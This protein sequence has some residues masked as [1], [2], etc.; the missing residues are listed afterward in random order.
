MNRLFD[1]H[2]KRS[3]LSLDGLWQF[4]TDPHGLGESDR[5][6]ENFPED[7]TSVYVPS[8]W[9]NELGLYDY[10][11]VAWYGKAFHS[12]GDTIQLA[13]HGVTG[14]ANVYLDGIFLG[15]HYGGFTGFDFTVND[16]KTGKHHLAVSVD[17]RH[18]D[19]D[20]IPLAV[21]DWFHYG[22]ITRGVEVIRLPETRIDRYRIDYKLS[23]DLTEVDLECQ[24]LVTGMSHPQIQ[25]Y[26]EGRPI[27]EN[28]CQPTK[29]GLG[30]LCQCH[31][32]DIQLW[33]PDH[34]NLYEIRIA[35]DGDEV[36]EHIGFRKIEAVNRQ[37]L[38]NGQPLYLKGVNRHEDHPDWGFALPVKL[39]MKDLAIIKSMGCNMI[40]GSHYPN[41][42]AFLDLC[43]REGILFMEEIPM[44]GFGQEALS[45][46]LVIERGL[47][48][49]EEMINRDYHHPCIFLW[50]LHNECATDTEA[51]YAITKAFAD[52]VRSLDQTRPITYATNK[53]HRDICLSLVDVISINKYV[54]WYMD[55]LDAWPAYLQTFKEKAE[56]DHLQD[57]PIIM[58]EFGAGALY[59]YSTFEG[60]KWSEN[61]QYNYLDY[62][63]KLFKDDPDISGAVLWQFC[64]IR[65]A[66]EH[67][68]GRPRSFNNKGILD[69]YRRPKAAYWT[70]KKHYSQ[71]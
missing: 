63:L 38:L 62:T 39:M 42:P 70:V 14:Q 50:G 28:P 26:I 15:S 3:H 64:D 59:G 23:E 40:R 2:P 56:K 32:K 8:C 67:E 45:N 10:E 51:G 44:W 18:N 52:K 30:L 7:A 54:G 48:M 43:D 25:V 12:E 55:T 47:M 5:W 49:H 35:I 13:F 69:E 17:N 33:H 19:H 20:T 16:L 41:A 31:L 53:S 29:Q 58:T 65:T 22:G 34:P 11:G 61:F 71:E 21:V 4:I 27:N 37:L 9:N 36:V 1:T 68:M 60:P 6:Y 24:V 66:K 57:K 46:P